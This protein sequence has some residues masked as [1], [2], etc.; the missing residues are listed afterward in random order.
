MI[1]RRSAGLAGLV[2]AS[3]GLLACLAGAVGV[4]AVKNR[5]QSVAAAVFTV[6]DDAFEFM[7]TRLVLVNERLDASRQQVDGLAARAQR[8]QTNETEPEARA[9][10]ES[11]R[12]TLDA[13]VSELQAAEGWL[14]SIE[15]VARGVNAAAE[16]IA[17]SRAESQSQSRPA[18]SAGATGVRAAK[19]AEFSNDLAEAVSRLDALREKLLEMRENRML[20]REAAEAMIAGAAEL[21]TRLA[22]LSRKIDDLGVR[23]SEARASSADASRRVRGWITFAAVVLTA[24][25]L[26]FGASQ[27]CVLKTV[28]RFLQRPP[29]E[30]ASPSS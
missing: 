29:R 15:A 23:L 8:L 13:V 16:S 9:E 2:L 25:L 21:D 24:V 18:E 17:E 26:W 19:V 27:A 3:L 4:W 10:V 20:A 6:A 12:T 11:L 14:D 5:A 22:N 28:W 30:K 1:I 7:A